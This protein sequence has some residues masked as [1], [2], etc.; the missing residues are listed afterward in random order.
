MNLSVEFNKP[1]MKGAFDW[2]LSQ[3]INVIDDDNNVVAKAEIELLTLNKHR[4]ADES[5]DLLIQQEATDWEVPLNLYFKKQNI[6][7]DLAEKLDVKVD[8]KA[9]THILI[10][11]ISVQPSHRKQGIAKLLLQA[12]AKQ[13]EK[14]QSI[15]LL[16]LAMNKFVDAQDCETETN[17]AYYESLMLDDELIDRNELS[18]V[19]EKLGFSQIKI[20]DSQLEEPLSFD[21][22]IASAHTLV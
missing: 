4:G 13:H 1:E 17:K 14:A 12:I 10:E 15:S 9:K 6:A 22:F 7:A 18:T 8:T 16:S 21:I 11:A 2:Q 3:E 19:F 20:D 5:Y